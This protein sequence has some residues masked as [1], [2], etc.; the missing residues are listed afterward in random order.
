ENQK[1][2]IDVLP[3]LVS[4]LCDRGVKG[5]F[6]SGTT[7]EGILTDLAE[8]QRLF[9]SVVP[10]LKERKRV[11]MLHVG[12]N[13]LRDTLALMETAAE[14]S[15]DAVALLPGYFYGLS[16]DAVFDY[17]K[18]A[19]GTFPE[20][21]IIG[22][23]IPHLAVNGFSPPLVK[24][25]CAEISNFAGLKSSC[26]DA[27]KVR[28]LIEAIDPNRF[29]L[30]GNEKMASGLLTLGATGIITGLSTA[31]PEP[32]VSLCNALATGD[33]VTARSNQDQINKILDMTPPGK[34]IGFI[35]QILVERGHDVGQ[36]IPPRPA[37]SGPFWPK[38]EAILA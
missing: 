33:L 9:E 17:F 4:F 12:T 16:D 26:T 25:M 29:V 30:T 2:K 15:A 37:A 35:K 10:L 31:V 32:F 36:P 24:R 23:D 14:L 11:S 38:I 7:G 27:L 18:A 5:L 3:G 8:R 34:R 21:P 6:I 22:Y 28:A 19:A 13:N 1:V 20:L